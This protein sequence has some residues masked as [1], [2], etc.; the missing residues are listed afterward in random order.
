MAKKNTTIDD[1]AVMVQKGF[2]ETATKSELKSLKFEMNQRF[3]KI[4]N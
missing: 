2:S 1:L 4:E 3:D